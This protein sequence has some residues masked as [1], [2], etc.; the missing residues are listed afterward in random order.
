MSNQ[1]KPFAEACEQNG[2][3]ILEVLRARL[4]KSCA[5]LEV[6]SGTGQHAVMFAAALE[7]VQWHTSDR[8]EG[9]T[10]IRMWL[11]EAQLPN[12]HPPISLDVLQDPWPE[13]QFDAV[14]SANTA[15]IMP[16]E[17][18]AAMFAGVA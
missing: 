8:E 5:L 18:V 15:H 11:D 16:E 3:P 9:H 7:T 13:R 6:G 4:P 1:R 10:G 12:V 2:P 14:F 17:A